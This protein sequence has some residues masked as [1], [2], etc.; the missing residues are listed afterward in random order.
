MFRV[1]RLLTLCTPLV[2]LHLCFPIKL[3]RSKVW[4]GAVH[5]HSAVKQNVV[6]NL[7]TPDSVISLWMNEVFLP[8]TVLN[9]S[10]HKNWKVGVNKWQFMTL[11]IAFH[12]YIKMGMCG[13]KGRCRMNQQR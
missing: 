9:S 13:S 5:D 4:V 2:V 12:G 6:H 8:L 7:V 3:V 10:A 1:N 11:I